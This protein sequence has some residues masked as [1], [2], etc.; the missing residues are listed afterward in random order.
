M[1]TQFKTTGTQEGDIAAGLISGGVYNPNVPVDKITPVNP[2]KLPE[3]PTTPDYNS[4]LAGVTSAESTVKSDQAEIMKNLKDLEGETGYELS[5]EELYGVNKNRK[6]LTNL[7]AQL[8]SINAEAAAATLDVDRVGRPAILTSAANLE[9]GN[10]ERDRTI[11]ALRLSSSIQ[12]IRGN[13]AL[14][15]DQVKRAVSLKYEPL[16]DRIKTLDKQLEF[17]YDTFTKA[18]K[19]QADFLKAQNE[20]ELKQLDDQQ[21]IEEKWV[22]TRNNALSNGAPV[23][24]INQADQ[25]QNIGK[26]NEARALLSRYTG[27]QSTEGDKT[28][29]ATSSMAT[30]LSSVAGPDGFIHPRDYQRALNAW[31]AKGYT[32]S[33]F[34]TTF[35]NF[36]NPND[37]YNTG[38]N[39]SGSGLDISFQDIPS[40]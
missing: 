21:K 39:N 5:Q 32:A 38:K 12:A 18:E 14:A 20:K 11:K 15:N 19:K 27:N 29:F 26:E 4:I 10:I 24:I 17:N 7:T 3:T 22:S 40:S 36:R 35:Q 34:H 30:E 9:K 25:L 37:T 2:V 13:L 23:S 8:N 28:K 31:V 33:S 6:E 16:K 1:A